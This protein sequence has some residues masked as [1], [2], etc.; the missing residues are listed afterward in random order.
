[1][2]GTN[3]TNGAQGAQGPPGRDAV[4]TCK[5]GK[6]NGKIVCSVS[7]KV[8]KATRMVS[9]RLMRGKRLYAS[10]RRAVH[11]GSVRLSLKTRRRFGA[12]RYVLRLALLDAGGSWR[13]LSVGAVVR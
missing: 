10:G 4:V 12:G 1:M 7:Y 11:A 5:A 13:T 2:N 9:A 3:G 6:G 8:G